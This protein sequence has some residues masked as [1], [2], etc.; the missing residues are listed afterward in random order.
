[1][2][3]IVGNRPKIVQSKVL[4]YKIV[5]LY[6]YLKINCKNLKLFLKKKKNKKKR[7]GHFYL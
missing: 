4:G 7:K 2:S 5:K 6:I 1:M 3:L